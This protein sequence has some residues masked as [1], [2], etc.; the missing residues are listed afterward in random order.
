MEFLVGAL[1]I[2]IVLIIYLCL[3][4][5]DKT[6]IKELKRMPDDLR[7]RVL[8]EQRKSKNVFLGIIRSKRKY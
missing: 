7:T 4:L 6:E 2:L 1:I 8:E 3:D 5:R